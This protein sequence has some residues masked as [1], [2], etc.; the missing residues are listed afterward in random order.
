VR[1]LHLQILAL[2]L[3]LP[4]GPG[5]P[6]TVERTFS[7]ELELVTESFEIIA[8]GDGGSVTQEGPHYLREQAEELELVDTLPE[9]E[10]PP[11]KF[12]RLYR[13]L[14]SSARLGTEQA[15]RERTASA[16]LEGKTVVFERDDDGKWNKTSADPGTRPVQL[17][18]LRAE[19]DLSVFL[20]G[21]EAS[22]PGDDWTVA[23][24][25][26]A[27]LLSPL[28]E[29]W[30][31]PRQPPATKEG[32]LDVAPAALIEPLGAMFAAAEGELSF[33]RIAHA[34]GADFPGSELPEHARFEFEFDST[35]DGA[36]RLL[37]G[38]EGEA[39][40]DARLRFTG[41]G[42]LAWDPASGAIAIACSGE[43]S[44]KESF[45]VAVEAAGKSG[46]MRGKLLVDGSLSLEA[47]ETRE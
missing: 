45:R 41:S 13:S 24:A 3:A 19:L 9:G 23:P 36:A 34:D 46:V 7:S 29:G 18:N 26:F 21:A 30:R 1:I 39:E 4:G 17:R 5:G 42:T 47:H 25:L 12:T 16:R 27:R 31:R 8:D 14:V 38:R 32:A 10:D 35:Y 22:D 28:E 20:P 44:I 15:P 2:A 43:L 11:A 33:T 6:R 40:D 37:G